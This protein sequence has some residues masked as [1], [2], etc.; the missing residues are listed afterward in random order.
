MFE[1]NTNLLERALN[2]TQGVKL[3]DSSVAQEY[4]KKFDFAPA[5]EGPKV[6]SC[7]A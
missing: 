3:N 7:D 2:L 5:N 1:L 4:R 6:T